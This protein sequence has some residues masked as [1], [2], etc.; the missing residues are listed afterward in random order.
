MPRDSNT[1]YMAVI[2]A[3]LLAVT[4]LAA[5]L[6]ITEIWLAQPRNDEP[7]FVT[8]GDLDNDN[9]QD[10]KEAA[11]ILTSLPDPKYKHAIG[12]NAASLDWAAQKTNLRAPPDLD[13]ARR[14]ESWST[15]I[16]PQEDTPIIRLN[17]QRYVVFDLPVT[18]GSTLLLRIA[19]TDCTNLSNE[20]CWARLDG[21]IGVDPKVR[22]V[23][24]GALVHHFMAVTYIDGHFYPAEP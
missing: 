10:A 12:I 16:K 18:E 14:R 9:V 22:A 11:V 2:I 24:D 19:H 3:Y 17:E 5:Y 20:F 6:T 1:P 7:N 13:P 8:D 21:V 15:V 4:T 23:P